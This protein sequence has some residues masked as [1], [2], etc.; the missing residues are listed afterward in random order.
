MNASRVFAYWWQETRT[1]SLLG[2]TKRLCRLPPP[3]RVVGTYVPSSAAKAMPMAFGLLRKLPD[4]AVRVLTRPT[5]CYRDGN[6]CGAYGHRCARPRVCDVRGVFFVGC[7]D[8]ASLALELAAFEV[9]PLGARAACPHVMFAWKD[10]SAFLWTTLFVSCTSI[11]SLALMVSGSATCIRN[12]T[13][14]S[15]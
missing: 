7:T 12:K 3:L 2:Q 6:I 13:V 1:R 14:H 10:M 9:S 8:I 5:T 4:S 11:A 15:I